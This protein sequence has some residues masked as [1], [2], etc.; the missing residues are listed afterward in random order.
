MLV[1][2]KQGVD[3]SVVALKGPGGRLALR[4]LVGRI[5]KGVRW[6]IL[7][8]SGTRH[9]DGYQLFN[10]DR[11]A[12]GTEVAQQLPPCDVVN[13]H[14]VAGFVDLKSFFPQVAPSIPVVWT[15][16]DMNAFTGGC[17]YDQDCGK[18][19][20][21]CGAC[22]VIDSGRENDV[23]RRIWRRK[24]RVLGGI[25]TGRLHVVTPSRWLEE[26]VRTSSLLGDRRVTVIP[27][28]IDTEVFA[29]RDRSLAREVLGIPPEAQVILFVAETLDDPR[30]GLGV[31]VEALGHL[32]GVSDMVAVST[33][34]KL[35]GIDVPVPHLHLGSV[36]SERL[37][38]LVY[39]A[40][41]V[42][43]I[44][45]LQDNLPNTVLESMACGTPVVGFAVGG[46]PDMVRPGITGLLAE[47]GDVAGLGAIL[48]ELLGNRKLRE[49][50]AASCRRMAKEE[51]ALEVQARRYQ[52][53][54]REFMGER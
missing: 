10:D 43:A 2:D 17:H 42:F 50:M 38:S 25:P 31:L 11:S 27:Y 3:P 7:G 35:P 24:R 13:L 54:Y 52:E 32:A 12:L 15:F 44:P 16:H 41:D 5:G 47:P 18:Y 53:L 29:P 49:S 6:Y 34:G 40:A 4:D 46:I 23:S 39:S 36:E 20:A 14:W 45:S 28:G 37:L 8:S 48:G 21:S 19:Q 30:K 22:P 1:R 26:A 51:Y 9:T 33:G